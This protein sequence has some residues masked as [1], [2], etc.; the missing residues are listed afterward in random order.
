MKKYKIVAVI[1]A[2][3]CLG[4]AT[5]VF[6]LNRH[7][8]LPSTGNEQEQRQETME[9]S[10]VSSGDA[11]ERDAAESDVRFI[12]DESETLDDDGFYCGELDRN[13]KCY[14]ESI[15]EAQAT[16][17]MNDAESVAAGFMSTQY[18]IDG[19]TGD[20]T[21]KLMSFTTNGVDEEYIGNIWTEISRCSPDMTFDDMHTSLISI[22]GPEAGQAEGDGIGEFLYV[23][24]VD[25]HGTVA[26]PSG[27]FEGEFSAPFIA[28]MKY[29]DDGCKISKI[30]HDM[31]VTGR[32]EVDMHYAPNTMTNQ[33]T[34]S[35][36]EE[37]FKWD[38]RNIDNYFAYENIDL[39]PYIDKIKS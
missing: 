24:V 13:V 29:T 36:G 28:Y 1:F 26:P 9:S 4:A 23:G 5:T 3:A 14:N 15:S 20:Y 7:E 2:V 8:P 34:I 33:I 39:S 18:T 35:T 30:C 10:P 25:F 27:N 38:F 21:D 11:G 19:S 17:V 37:L 12:Q 22:Y 6:I 32:G 16:K 31:A